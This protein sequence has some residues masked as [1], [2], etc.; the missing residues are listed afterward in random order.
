MLDAM[1]ASSWKKLL[2][3]HVRFRQRVSDEEQRAEKHDRF[4][5]GRP[6][7]SVINEHCRATGGQED[8]VTEAC[9]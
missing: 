8:G 7:A 5:R 1:I 6:I 9:Q 2:D 3:R 4:L